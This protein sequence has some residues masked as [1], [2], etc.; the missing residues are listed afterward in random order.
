M[1][2]LI[3]IIKIILNIILII[4]ISGFIFI[5]IISSTILKKDYILQVLEKTKYYSE[6]GKEIQSNFENYIAQS[7]LEKDVIENIV[8]EEKIKNDTEIIISNIYE[9]KKQIVDVTEIE[10]NLKSNIE[11]SL[12]NNRLNII[13]KDAINQF[14]IKICDQY[15]ETMSYTKYEN[16]INNVLNR[17]NKYINILKKDII[18][19]IIILIVIVLIIN[20]KNI[21]KGFS[22]LCTIL[23]ANG[24]LCIIFNLYI[25]YEIKVGDILILNNAVSEVIK[26]LINDILFSIIRYGT[27]LVVCGFVGIVIVNIS[28]TKK[29]IELNK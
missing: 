6:I 9:G 22:Q 10:E 4:A 13:Q 28:I 25:N 23:I 24:I 16:N 20:C 3:Q 12:K 29:S 1:K 27:L 17:I 18:I 15:K 7:G 14:V 26:Q 5:N 19:A 8:S 2:I 11:K 21:I